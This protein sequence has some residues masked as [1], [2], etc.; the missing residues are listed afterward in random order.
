[1]QD[2]RTALTPCAVAS[3]VRTIVVDQM[4]TKTAKLGEVAEH[5]RTNGFS[6]LTWEEF[7]LV[8][9]EGIDDG[10]FAIDSSE[11]LDLPK[12]TAGGRYQAAFICVV[13]QQPG[14]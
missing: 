5:L 14:K 11:R 8:V 7:S 6:E 4:F 1:M 12:V 3:A 2:F 9:I 10:L 13:R